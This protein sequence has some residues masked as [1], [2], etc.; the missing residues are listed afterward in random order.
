[1]PSGCRLA[2]K[3]VPNAPRDAIMGWLGNSLK[4]KIRAPASGGRA[5]EALC[6][7]LAREFGLPRRAVT[8][9]KGGKSR[10]KILQIDGLAEVE[11]RARVG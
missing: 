4:V 7:L 6:N 1:M 10:Q 2:V 11:I 3:A 8:L 5:N 9:V